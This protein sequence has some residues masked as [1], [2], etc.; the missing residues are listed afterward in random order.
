MFKIK[1]IYGKEIKSFRDQIGQLRIEV[2]KEYPYLYEGDLSYERKYLETY[3]QSEKSLAVLVFKDKKLVG[4]STCI[5]LIDEEEGFQ[6]PFKVDEYDLSKIF[7]F[8]ESIIL[9]EYRGN[10]F[11]RQFFEERENHSQ[12]VMKDLELTTFC[13]VL[14]DKNHPLRP[15]EYRPLDLMWKKLGY[16]PL[17]E[18]VL[19]YKWKDIDKKT[20][21]LKRLVCWGKNWST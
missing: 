3:I 10:G 20:E 7:Y 21:D 8:G 11:G 19:E 13:S 1:N 12:R 5:P 17:N 18:K 2:F 15:K 6:K 16:A 4:T 9:K 14:R